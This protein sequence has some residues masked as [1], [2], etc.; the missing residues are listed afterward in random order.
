MQIRDTSVE[1]GDKLATVAAEAT[2]RYL[3]DNA[4]LSQREGLFAAFDLKHDFPTEW[5]KVMNPPPAGGTERLL[6]LNDLHERLPFFTRAWPPDK[7]RATDVYLITPVAL[8]GAALVLVQ[9]SDEF[10][11]DMNGPTFGKM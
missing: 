7:I 10:P 11:F 8:S 6:S 9:P 1:G 4:E 2:K 5:S 3:K